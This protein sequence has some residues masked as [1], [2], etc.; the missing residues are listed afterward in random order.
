MSSSRPLVDLVRD[1]RAAGGNADER[2]DALV[3]RGRFTDW[4]MQSNWLGCV[5]APPPPV[6]AVQVYDPTIGGDVAEDEDFDPGRVITITVVKP[7]EDGFR[8]FFF[9]DSLNKYL[10]GRSL[11]PA[12]FVA[13]LPPEGAFRA[14]GL[15]VASWIEGA[16]LNSPPEPVPIN[17]SK[18]VIDHVPEREVPRDLAPW[19]LLTP[20]A[21]HSL[22]FE[23]WRALAARRLLSG[24]VSS[25]FLEDGVVWLQASGPPIYR[26]RADDSAIAQAWEIL[27]ET[28]AWVFLSGSD[29]EARHRLFSGELARAGRPGQDFSNTLTRAFEA[30]KVAYEAHVQS[31]SR[32]TLKA[33]ADLRKTVIEETQRVTQRTQDMA[34]GLGRDLAASAAPFALKI[35]ADAG[36]VSTPLVSASFYFA[37]SAFVAVSFALQW[38][39]NNAFLCSQKASR[40]RWMQTLYTY[41]STKE[42]EEI[43]DTPI[44]Q[45]MKNYRETR[46]VLLVIYVALTAGLGAAGIYTLLNQPQPTSQGSTANAVAPSAPSKGSTP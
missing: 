45:A 13:D 44:E 29:I 37:V 8:C 34:S 35:L 3:L 5:R 18:L 36:K 26:V 11:A 16:P 42:R 17:P 22:A 24:L 31:A 23:V 32:E 33:L 30:A 41:I 40:L 9:Q 38:R 25:A 7:I 1:F 6:T 27:N 15:D 4:E 28:A 21:A 19:M 43:A 46:A 12:L 20:P 39:I 2:A 10:T 14:R